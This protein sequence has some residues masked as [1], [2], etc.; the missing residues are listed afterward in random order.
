MDNLNLS[1]YPIV[2]KNLW[3]LDESILVNGIQVNRGEASLEI[4]RIFSKN[5][6]GSH[7]NGVKSLLNAIFIHSSNN[8]RNETGQ[9]NLIKRINDTY[10]LSVIL[11]PVYLDDTNSSEDT[12]KKAI[13][14][15][16]D[17]QNNL[18]KMLVKYEILNIHENIK[19][20][21]EPWCMCGHLSSSGREILENTIHKMLN[22]KMLQ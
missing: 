7:E 15:L 10:D 3:R 6:C 13:D 22:D 8:F 14:Q 20:Y 17:I 16:I 5:R 9:F 12:R 11:V 4:K 21:D 18:D 2:K 1:I 19:Y